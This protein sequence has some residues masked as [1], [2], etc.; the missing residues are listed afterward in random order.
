MPSNASQQP[1]RQVEPEHPA[2]SKRIDHEAAEGRS[3]AEA[4]RL[5]GGLQPEGP[6]APRSTRRRNDDGD[7]VRLQQTR[8]QP[9]QHPGADQHSQAR[10]QPTQR[11]A[12]DEYQETAA[13]HQLAAE[14]VREAP[15]NR[16]HR[17]DDE[18][19]GDRHPG[20][21][22]DPGMELQLELRQHDLGDAGVHLTHERADADGSDDKPGIGVEARHGAQRRRLVP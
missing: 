22:A 7:A 20:D 6:P 5:R 11:R 18:Q 1:D 14:H 8:A 4:D 19:I 13:V 21:R 17:G 10:R 15:E 16:Q 3:D 2:P 12:S 9:L